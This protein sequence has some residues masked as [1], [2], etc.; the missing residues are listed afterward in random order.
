M[1]CLLVKVGVKFLMTFCLFSS[2]YFALWWRTVASRRAA[3]A[4]L[5]TWYLCSFF[6]SRSFSSARLLPRVGESVLFSC[7]SAHHRCKA[8]FKHARAARACLLRNP[9]PLLPRLC[10]REMGKKTDAPPVRL[11]S[12]KPKS[13]MGSGGG[14]EDNRVGWMLWCRGVTLVILL[15]SFLAA[16]FYASS[17]VRFVEDVLPQISGACVAFCLLSP[18]SPA[19]THP[20]VARS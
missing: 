8:R 14:K 15:V 16:I 5:F 3:A 12:M 17:R 13:M 10:A 7:S 9:S 4:R 11:T 6:F 18:Y 2:L 19:C 1:Q 20:H